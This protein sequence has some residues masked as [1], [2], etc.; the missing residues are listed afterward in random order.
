MTSTDAFVL[1]C[2]ITLA[3]YFKDEANTYADSI[4]DHFYL[5]EAFVPAIW[6]L[7]LA[8]A[9]LTGERRKRSTQSQASRWMGYLDSLPITI[10]YALSPRTLQDILSLAR[11]ENLSAYDA[12]YLELAIRRGLP[13]ATLDDKLMTAASAV[14]IS[15]Y[16]PSKRRAR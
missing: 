12:S 14:G 3:W 16:K 8:N 7:E 1:D 9:L 13:I 2:S 4:R 11:A 10:D 15:A 6:P 5:A